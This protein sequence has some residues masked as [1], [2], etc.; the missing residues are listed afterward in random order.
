MLKGMGKN[1]YLFAKIKNVM[2]VSLKIMRFH[3]VKTASIKEA[4]GTRCISIK[5]HFISLYIALYF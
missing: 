3:R 5:C 4:M 2:I 1:L